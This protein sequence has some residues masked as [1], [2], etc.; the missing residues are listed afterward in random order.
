MRKCPICGDK[1]SVDSFEI[2][3][4]NDTFFRTV[5]KTKIC[6]CRNQLINIPTSE[7]VLIESLRLENAVLKERLQEF[8]G[9]E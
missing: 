1:W 2:E 5:R 9:R 7:K 6:A 3:K 4:I 8:E